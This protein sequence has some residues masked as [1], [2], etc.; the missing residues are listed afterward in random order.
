MLRELRIHNLAIIDEIHLSFEDGMNVLTGETGAGKSIIMRAIGLL[1]GERATADLLRTDADEATAEG[2]FE[3]EENEQACLRDAGLA[4]AGEVLIRRV[5]ARNGKG[6]VYVNGALATAGLLAQLGSRLI[7]IYGQHEQALLLKPESHIDYLDEFGKLAD[8]RARMGEGWT[9]ARAAEAHL[10]RLCDSGEAARQ[11]LELLQFQSKEL[12]DAA[13]TVGEEARLQQER[14]LQR[15]A[16]RLSQ[17]CQVGEESLYSGEQAVAGAVG[18]VLHQLQEAE[19]IDP[20][21][22]EIIEHVRHAAMSIDEAARELRRATDRFEHDPARLQEIDDRLA[23]LTRLKR[24]YGCEVDEL[25]AKLAAFTAE[26]E[27]AEGAGFDIASARGKAEEAAAAAWKVAEELSRLRRSVAKELE[28]KVAQEL[29]ALGM[30]GAVFR[31]VFAAR[32]GSDRTTAKTTTAGLTAIGADDVELYLSANPG[33]DPK[34]LARIASGGELSR[35]ML[36]LKTLTAGAGEVPTLIFDEVDAGIGG[37]VAEAVGQRLA[38]LA[39]S[40]QV[41]CITHLPQIA[42]QA[43]HHFVIEK[44]VTKGRTRSSARIVQADERIAEIARMLGSEATAE[45]QQYARKL[46]QT[47]RQRRR[48]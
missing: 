8:L 46:M 2:L 19:R 25:A 27:S 44:R 10:A 4:A 28:K 48:P 15:H 5:V 23:L 9:A 39:T 14:E 37:T 45:S 38:A 24:K 36:A 13:V 43:D 35:I 18:R 6:K 42:S 16:E 47:S 22:R 29:A 21:F 41:L 11:R 7:H 17:I 30:R 12:R 32:E 40:R 34:P 26:V 31:I 3:L 1:C 33:E 20:S